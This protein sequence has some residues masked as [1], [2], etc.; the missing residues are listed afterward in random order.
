MFQEGQTNEQ[1]FK[2]KSQVVGASVM[3]DD[4]V[5]SVD[6]RI[7]GRQCFANSGASCEFPQI[8]RTLLYKSITVR[9]D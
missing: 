9:L 6:S 5:K 2:M 8:S 4:I 7:W 3:S 1:I